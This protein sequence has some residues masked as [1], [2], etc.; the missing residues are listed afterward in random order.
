MLKAVY[1]VGSALFFDTNK[2]VDYAYFYDTREEKLEALKKHRRKEGIDV[3]FHYKQEPVIFLG[4]YSNPYM[5]LIEGEEI[6]ALKNFNLLD[7]KDEYI[8]LVKTYVDRLPRESKQWY[9]IYFGISILDR[10]KTK[11]TKEQIKI[12]KKIHDNGIDDD[13]YNY[14]ID[15]LNKM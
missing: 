14:I 8:A 4:C 7:Y 6:E 3:H 11:I 10:G 5:E 1:K 15:Y 13:L 9:H 2:D 12:A